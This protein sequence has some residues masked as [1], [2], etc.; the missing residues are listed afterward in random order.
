MYRFDYKNK[1]T[2]FVLLST[3]AIFIQENEDRLRLG[4][5][6]KQD[7]F[8]IALNLRYLC[9]IFIR[10]WFNDLVMSC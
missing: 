2:Y 7:L 5:K 6:N 8:C 3:C 10:S 4:N 1:Y 9:T